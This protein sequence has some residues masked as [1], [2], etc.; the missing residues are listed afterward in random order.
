[1]AALGG[2]GNRVLVV[3]GGMDNQMVCV[4]TLGGRDCRPPRSG[5]CDF[6]TVTTLVDTVYE[7]MA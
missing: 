5:I 2:N 7:A 1:M 4:G 3:R 6:C